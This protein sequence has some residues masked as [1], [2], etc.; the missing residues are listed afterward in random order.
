VPYLL[1]FGD[2]NK[3]WQWEAFTGVGYHFHW[4][5]ISLG[6]RNLEYR[7][8]D[9]QVVFNKVRFTGPTLA[10]TFHW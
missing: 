5:D 10:A 4:G 6:V 2:G 8:T 9:N 1:D 3:N 7:T